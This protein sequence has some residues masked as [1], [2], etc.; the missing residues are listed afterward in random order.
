MPDNSNKE[1]YHIFT[2]EEADLLITD[3]L[4]ADSEPELLVKLLLIIHD[5]IQEVRLRDSIYLLMKAA[6]IFPK[7]LLWEVV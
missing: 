7:N 5:H 3:A 2:D 1:P 6:F 4:Y